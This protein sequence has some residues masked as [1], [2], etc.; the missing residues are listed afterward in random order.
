MKKS[1]FIIIIIIILAGGLLI[2]KNNKK[3]DEQNTGYND[4]IQNSTYENNTKDESYNVAEENIQDNRAD[5]N[6]IQ[7][8]SANAENTSSNKEENSTFSEQDA[9]NK[10][11]IE[12]KTSKTSNEK[13]ENSNSSVTIKEKLTPSG[14]MGSSLLKV[15]L[16]SNGDVYILYYDGAGYEEKNIS[17]KKLIATK[18]DSVYYRGTGEDFEA[19]VVKG[20]S[21]MEIKNKDYAWIDFE[22]PK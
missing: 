21:D 15:A 7:N 14:F 13:N 6:I 22:N 8:V 19:I 10:N 2:Y 4:N 3:N 1:L 18:A 5:E 20:G 12:N 17:D 11:A 16:Y 9:N